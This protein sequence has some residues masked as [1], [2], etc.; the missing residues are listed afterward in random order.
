MPLKKENITSIAYG[1]NKTP[2]GLVLIAKTEKGLSDL[3]FLTKDKEY[4]IQKLFK[5][6]PKA[7]FIEDKPL[8]QSYIEK[9]FYQKDLSEIKLHLIGTDFQL[10]VW[11][12]LLNIP[13]GSVVSY[14]DIAEFIK[15][16]KATRAVGNA[17]GKNPLQYIIPCHR[18]IRNDGS[19]GGFAA[20]AEKKQLILES[21][22]YNLRSGKTF[23]RFKT[24][25]MPATLRSKL[26]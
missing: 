5:K 4:F 22:N 13:K 15:N 3:Q 7:A 19:I 17:V 24:I 11:Q 26:V 9:I 14:S 18:V 16:P 10:I 12:A 20:G 8:M 25:A 6:Y 2:F 23:T 21:E 1:I